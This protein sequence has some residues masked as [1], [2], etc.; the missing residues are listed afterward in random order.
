[1]CRSDGPRNGWE[2]KNVVYRSPPDWLQGQPSVSG[3]HDHRHRQAPSDLTLLPDNLAAAAG[4][5]I[6]PVSAP[7]KVRV[8]GSIPPSTG[9]IATMHFLRH[10]SLLPAFTALTTAQSDI[11][12]SPALSNIL[13]HAFQAPLYTYVSS[14][15]QLLTK[16]NHYSP[17][18]LSQ[19]PSPKV[20][21]PRPCTPTTTTGGPS[22]STPPSAP[23]PSASKPTSGSSTTPCTSATNPPPSLPPERSTRSTSAPSSTC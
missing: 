15:S 6:Y 11:P 14:P 9:S 17:L 23:A 19:P 13:S 1:M 22:P 21:S 18:H 7:A 3:N 4:K 16:P 20:S 2:R 12:L 10:L 8:R 5:V